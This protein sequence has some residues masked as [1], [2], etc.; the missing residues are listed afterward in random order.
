MTQQT[1]EKQTYCIVTAVKDETGALMR[2]LNVLTS[3]NY[4]IS[5][6]NA[7]LVDVE[8]RITRVTLFSELD[9]NTANLIAKK[10]A[11]IISVINVSV[12]AYNGEYLENEA[13]LI[14]V[15]GNKETISKAIDAAYSHG[16]MVA[17]ITEDT[18]V[19]SYCGSSTKINQ[20]IQS[21]QHFG[22]AEVSRSGAIAMES[23]NKI[24]PLV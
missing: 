4:N 22:I 10:I 3:R 21:L 18:V 1:Q 8:K 16:A 19:F 24:L 9:L 2:I 13:S 6:V 7:T 15:K 23:G 20:F 17:N 12:F 14:K 11:N 5:T